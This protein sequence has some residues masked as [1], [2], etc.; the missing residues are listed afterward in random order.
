M[1]AAVLLLAL[2]Q[3]PA[4]ATADT[5]RGRPCTVV[6]TR[7]GLTFVNENGQAADGQMIGTGQVAVPAWSNLIGQIVPNGVAI[8][9]PPA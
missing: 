3:Q 2:V 1:I 9:R 8:G 7:S 5:A 4:P 6:E